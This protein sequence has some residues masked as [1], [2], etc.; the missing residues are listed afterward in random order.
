VRT[1]GAPDDVAMKAAAEAVA[2]H[3]APTP[4]LAAPSLGEGV[5]LKLETFQPTGSFKVRGALAAL[6]GE[7]EGGEL[8]NGRDAITI[9]QITV[10]CALGYLDLRYADLAWRES[11]PKVAKWFSVFAER[12]SMQATRPPA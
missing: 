12:P 4:V 2:R 10:G 5:V 6:D 9:G 3:L 11:A 1:V 8:G 7:A